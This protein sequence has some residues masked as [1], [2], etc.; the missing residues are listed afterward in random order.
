MAM[1]TVSR[2]T[3]TYWAAFG[4]KDRCQLPDRHRGYHGP[5]PVP[6]ARRTDP[7]TSHEAAQTVKNSAEVR[8]RVYRLLTAAPLTD[9][10]VQAAYFALYG[11]TASPS[12][13]RTRRS[14]L[15]DAG[16]VEATPDRRPTVAG[17]DS[18]VWRAKP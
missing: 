5:A 12:G 16:R 9:E 13:L 14:E 11:Q 2:C 1:A 4:V 18:I 10:G 7:Q 3:G 6:A 17:R 8:E 15:V